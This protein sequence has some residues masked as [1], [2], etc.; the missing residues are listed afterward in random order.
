MGNAVETACLEDR[1]AGRD[2]DGSAFRIADT[3][4]A[5][6]AFAHGPDRAAKQGQSDDADDRQPDDI[7]NVGNEPKLLAVG[8]PD[9]AERILKPV[10]VFRQGEGFLA[11]CVEA[12]PRQDRNEDREAERGRLPCAE[13]RFQAQPHVDPD[14]AVDPSRKQARGLPVNL[15]RGVFPQGEEDERVCRSRIREFE[16]APRA[17]EMKREK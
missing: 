11:G 6:L 4:A 8:R 10:P 7:G 13:A 2:T 3:D 1:D 12:E 16:C 5:A 14:A 9:E 15:R 17:G